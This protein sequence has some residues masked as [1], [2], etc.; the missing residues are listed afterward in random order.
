MS[1]FYELDPPNENAEPQLPPLF[2]SEAVKGNQNPFSKAIVAATAGDVGTLYYSP[3]N[4]FLNFA[5]TLGPEVERQRALQVHFV[6][7]LGFS[8]ALGALAPPEID[9]SHIWPN[10]VFMNRGLVGRVLLKD[11]GGKKK[12]YSILDSFWYSIKIKS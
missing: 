7:M 11:S 6:M 3:D 10:L 1:M 12:E 4:D 5:I 2:K 9:I 8:D